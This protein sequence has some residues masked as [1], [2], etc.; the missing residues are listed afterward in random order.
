[1][2]HEICNVPAVWFILLYD[3]PPFKLSTQRVATNGPSQL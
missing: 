2:Y 3:R 1:M